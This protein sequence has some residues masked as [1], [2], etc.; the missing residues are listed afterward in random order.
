MKQFHHLIICEIEPEESRF[1]I[2]NLGIFPFLEQQLQVRLAVWLSL[3]YL[4]PDNDRQLSGCSGYGGVSAFSV[5]DSFEEWGE[6]ML[7]LIS[8][9]VCGLA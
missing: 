2:L 8:Y 9:A 4:I 6:R 5:S 1:D 3:S 7:F